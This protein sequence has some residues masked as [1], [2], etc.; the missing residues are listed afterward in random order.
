MRYR[1][2]SKSIGKNGAQADLR[3]DVPAIA[4]IAGARVNHSPIVT[5]IEVTYPKGRIPT[6]RC[7]MPA[8]IIKIQELTKNIGPAKSTFTNVV[9]VNLLSFAWRR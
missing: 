3:L 5:T 9:M 6:S 7:T 1:R 4:P 2:A 8:K